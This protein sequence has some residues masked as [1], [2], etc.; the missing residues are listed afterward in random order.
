[1][2]SSTPGGS[3][4]IKYDVLGQNVGKYNLTASMTSDVTQGTATTLTK[5]K[6]V[7]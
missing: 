3:E 7:P 4:K 6:V 2:G 1:V 5:V